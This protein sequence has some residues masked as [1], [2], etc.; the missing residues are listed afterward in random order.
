M[1]NYIAKIRKQ[2]GRFLAYVVRIDH[3]GEEAVVNDYLMRSFKTLAAAEKST[4]N[5]INKIVGA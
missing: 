2:D 4:R 1:S 5:H 3:D